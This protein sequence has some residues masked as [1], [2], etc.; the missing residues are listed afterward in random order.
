MKIKS[1]LRK[2]AQ[3]AQSTFEVA[4]KAGSGL[5]ETFSKSISYDAKISSL[6]R[7]GILAIEMG[8]NLL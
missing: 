3:V 8:K 5:R 1:K 2:L 6:W 7:S 4:D